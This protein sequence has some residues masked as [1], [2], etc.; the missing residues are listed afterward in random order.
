MTSRH[1]R[2]KPDTTPLGHYVAHDAPLT[3]RPW[4]TGT[5]HHESRVAPEGRL[6]TRCLRDASGAAFR[7][8]Y[9]RHDHDEYPR[10]EGV[11][12]E[13]P[14]RPCLPLPPCRARAT[15]RGSDGSR[16][17]RTSL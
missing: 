9:D 10:D 3:T 7:R 17:H 13:A 16:I 5:R 11:F 4:S 1:V 8:L 15:G 6:R 12:E 14:R 2:L